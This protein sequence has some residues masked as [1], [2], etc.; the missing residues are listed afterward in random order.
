MA[1]LYSFTDTLE[2][3]IARYYSTRCDHRALDRKQHIAPTIVIR[4]PLCIHRGV[5]AQLYYRP[6]VYHTV[7]QQ[8]TSY[9]TQTRAL[10]TCPAISVI[11]PHAKLWGGGKL[12][13]ADRYCS[14][15]RLVP[16]L[17]T[18]VNVSSQMY[19][20]AERLHAADTFSAT[21]PPRLVGKRARRAAE[22][23]ANSLEGTHCID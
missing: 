16:L 21:T 19:V 4:R 9:R 14:C 18:A 3:L 22:N 1:I 13:P 11:P 8:E 10:D 15:L 7:Y 12:Q 2:C 6:V 17:D 20:H 5:G 23:E